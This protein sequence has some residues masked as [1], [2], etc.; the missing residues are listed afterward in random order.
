MKQS[1][2]LFLSMIVVLFSCKNITTE[3]VEQSTINA[4]LE[5]SQ[6][7]STLFSAG[8]MTPEVL[9]KLGRVSDIQV[10]PDGK[11]I[12]YGI[13]RYSI[14]KNKGERDLYV[15]N[16]NSG[17][18]HRLTNFKGSEYNGL[19]RPDGKKIGF[20][21]HLNG[22][23]QLW[24][25]NPN[26]SKARQISHIKGGITAFKYSPDGKHILY[27]ANVKVDKTI[28]DRYPDL[29]KANAKIY[30]ELMYRHWDH[31]R[32][33]YYSHVFVSKYNSNTIKAGT[34]LMKGERYNA[35]REPF[36]GME[37]INWSPDGSKISISYKRLTGKDYALS[38]N[39]EVYIYD[40][41]T[42]K[43]YNLTKDGFEGYDDGAVWS[44]NGKMIV[45]SS[46]KTPGFESDKNRIIVYNFVTG[47]TT[48]YSKGFDQSSTGFVFSPDSKTI[49]FISGV[50][51]T[52]QVYALDLATK[53]IKQLTHGDHNYTTIALADGKLV[54]T[55]MSM[56]EPTEIY[57]IDFNGNEKQLSFTN[58]S[59]LDRIMPAE[60]EKRWVATT[61]GKKELV[62]V[63]YPPHFDK[64]KKYPTLLYCQGGPQSAVSQFF[65]Y[66]W[67]FQVMA[68]NGY[69]VVA[70]NRRGLPTFG[71]A[72]N[73]QIS[74]DYGGQ[75]MKDYLSAIDAVSQEPY[76]DKDRL[77]AV[78]ASYGGYS[79][80]W[81]AGHHQ[82]RFKALIAHCGI[83]DLP[84]MYASTEETFFV[85]HDLGGAVWD[86]PQP[87]SYTKFN[88]ANFV[89]QW[90][91]P[92]LVIS[93]GNDFRIPYSQSMQAFNAAR[94]HNIPSRFLFFPDES[95]FVVQ[96]QNS[97]LW[98]R[99]FKAFLDKYL[100]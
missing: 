84:S 99:E 45:W 29:P 36:N 54:G 86:K 88:P 25:V 72:W 74:G 5:I 31:W 48:D 76:V 83:Y 4:P 73:D 18:V 14:K 81:L 66:R 16:I 96:P 93:G 32:D 47:D 19:W 79:I 43:S 59:I 20:L 28:H 71:Q 58:K 95:H 2:F 23:T 13:S 39:S 30:D 82:G 8:I 3:K 41:Y 37:D 64:T 68:S 1:I 51:A 97:I 49:Y 52:Y 42:G 46:M 6:N 87:K 75:N 12:V 57:S 69:I 60:V 21:R 78:G 24:E 7:D 89:G 35:P 92:I 17:K 9:W 22:S 33:A 10:S 94:L 100:K 90:D 61:D 65:S 70:P 26:G 15:L 38:T 53:K 77:G 11:N 44:P 62:W 85:K 80:Y 63:I 50:N 34:D 27:T 56:K 67:N 55:K 98:Q 40:I 91:T